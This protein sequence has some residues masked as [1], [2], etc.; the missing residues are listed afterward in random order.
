MEVGGG[1]PANSDPPVGCSADMSICSSGDFIK[2]V[3]DNPGVMGP[4]G[5]MPIM[6]DRGMDELRMVTSATEV[7]SECAFSDSVY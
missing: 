6:Q 7:A 1:T 5:A 3:F 4:V 2:V